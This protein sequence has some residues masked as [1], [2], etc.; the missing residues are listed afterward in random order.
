MNMYA[1]MLDK[2]FK[3][4]DKDSSGEIDKAELKGVLIAW[5]KI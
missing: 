3:D 4:T 1:M 5:R 2:A